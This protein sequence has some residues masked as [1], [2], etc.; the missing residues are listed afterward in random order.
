MR[1]GAA[2]AAV[3]RLAANIAAVEAI[4]VFLII[5][6]LSSQYINSMGIDARDGGRNWMAPI[7]LYGASSQRPSDQLERH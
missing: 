3:V 4:I 2:E 6:I 7:K 5:D 1:S